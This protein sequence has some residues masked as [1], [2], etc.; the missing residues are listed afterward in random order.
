MPILCTAV[1]FSI[2]NFETRSA[3][4]RAIDL[5]GEMQAVHV[6]SLLHTLLA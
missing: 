6:I 3:R 1:G 4:V 5:S 2:E